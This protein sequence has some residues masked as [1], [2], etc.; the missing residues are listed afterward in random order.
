MALNISFFDQVKTYVLKGKGRT[1]GKRLECL[2][3][4]KYPLSFQLHETFQPKENENIKKKSYEHLQM[5]NFRQ[6]FNSLSWFNGVFV[7]IAK[8]VRAQYVPR[9][10][11]TG[12]RE[13]R[14]RIRGCYEKVQGYNG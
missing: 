14:A 12:E 11:R 10:E 13:V 8:F 3:N 6:L 1:R 4:Y 5:Q 9:E 7:K 2:K